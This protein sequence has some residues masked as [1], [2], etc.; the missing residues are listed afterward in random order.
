M[1]LTGIGR[2]RTLRARPAE[3]QALVQGRGG[4]GEAE[5]QRVAPVEARARRAPCARARTR[6]GQRRSSSVASTVRS[7][8]SRT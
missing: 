6:P 4:A 2:R 5:A 8:P 1:P 7:P 3:R